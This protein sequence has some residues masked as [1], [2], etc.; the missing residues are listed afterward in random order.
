MPSS[1]GSSRPRR[2]T[3]PTARR[4]AVA[5]PSTAPPRVNTSA[6]EVSKRAKTTAVTANLIG[7]APRAKSVPARQEEVAKETAPEPV[8]RDAPTPAFR[9][10]T[11]GVF[12][13]SA[14]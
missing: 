7:R 2:A 14:Q 12:G 4:V 8:Q 3:K 1:P 9:G 6:S 11:T 13:Y 10:L 5:A